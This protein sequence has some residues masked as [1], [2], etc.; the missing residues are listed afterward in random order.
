MEAA[1]T[2]VTL[3]HGTFAP[4]AEWTKPGSELRRTIEASLG[5]SVAFQTF[6][7]SGR[8]T[9][10]A[11]LAAGTEFAEFIRGLVSNY[12]A[13]EHFIIAHSHGGNV[14]LYG[15]RDETLLRHISGVVCLATPFIRTVPRNLA[16]SAITM[17]NSVFLLIFAAP[18][19]VLFGMFVGAVMENDALR[20][21]CLTLM[22]PT[23]GVLVAAAFLGTMVKIWGG[24]PEFALNAAAKL[25]HPIAVRQERVLDRLS[26]PI[27]SGSRILSVSPLGDEAKGG[28]GMLDRIANTPFRWIER[29]DALLQAVVGGVE[30]LSHTTE[31]A[32]PVIYAARL[33]RGTGLEAIPLTLALLFGIPVIF[34]AGLSASVVA[35]LI[36]V[37]LVCALLP[38]GRKLGYWGERLSD[39]LF[40]EISVDAVPS[41]GRVELAVV[42][43]TETV[44]VK[45]WRG[46]SSR[47]AHC[48]I[49]ENA[50]A[51][52]VVTDWIGCGQCSDAHPVTQPSRRHCPP[53]YDDWAEMVMMVVI[54]LGLLIGVPFMILLLA[55]AF[56]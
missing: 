14:A 47:L 45:P 54:A 2:I 55:M 51:L 43:V 15:L 48:A 39:Y 8:N 46:F 10:A 29:L 42:D 44:R 3:V 31:K 30:V 33:F 12:P 4:D 41:H 38:H 6:A 35:G 20:E 27:T 50:T 28:L 11:R 37:F 34:L 21:L 7:W 24:A 13:S 9:H 1:G 18:F 52:R 53:N 56:G 26:L 17:W 32:K 19:L 36:G 49:Y 40:A 22:M 23:F 5:Q 25:Y 16:A